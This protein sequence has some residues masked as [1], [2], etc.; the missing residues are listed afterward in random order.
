MVRCPHARFKV[1]QATRRYVD[2]FLLNANRRFDARLTSLGID[3]EYEEFPDA[4][5]W[6]YWDQHVREVLAF[7]ARAV[8]RSDSATGQADGRATHYQ[9]II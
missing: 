4:R 1:Y 5:T 9:I 7:H 2:D 3:H 8:S 6:D